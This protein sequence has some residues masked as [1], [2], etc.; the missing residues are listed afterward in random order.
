MRILMLCFEYPP[1]GGG[2]SKVVNGLSRELARFGHEIDIVTMGYR[3]LPKHE[4][5][6]GVNIYRLRP[7]RRDKSV[8]HT[9]EMAMHDLLAV[10]FVVKLINRKQYDLNHTHFIFPDGLTALLAHK[11]TGLPYII[12]AHGSDVPGYNPDRFTYQHKLFAP[13]WHVIVRNSRKIICPSEN[14]RSLVVARRKTVGTCIIPNALD[15]LKFSHR[16]EKH[17]R[18]L[19]VTRMF[20]RK[21]VQKIL[22]VLE[23]TDFP[24]EFN[25][26]GDGPYLETLRRIA[27]KLNTSIKFWGWLDNDS[28]ELKDLYETS[29][30]FI[31][32]SSSENFPINLLEAMAAGMA[33]ITNS[34]SGCSEVVGNAALKVNPED[35]NDIR[36]SLLKL[37]NDP[38]L[39][40]ELGMQARQRFE[41]HFTWSNVAQQHDRLYREIAKSETLE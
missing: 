17:T 16:C 12:T 26:V 21:G 10:P 1:L 9:I 6:D 8:C 40:K 38:K 20:Q 39:C 14:L 13:M 27:A 7:V 41:N 19:I 22:K 29:S 34:E 2:G 31:F 36:D 37:S 25:I 35:A 5:F 28:R 11:L 15:P 18:V 4:H 3:G 32:L 24:F 33:I 30:I 23:T